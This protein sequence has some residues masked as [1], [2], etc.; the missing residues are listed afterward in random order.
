MSLPANMTTQ[1][2]TGSTTWAKCCKLKTNDGF[3]IGLTEH[4]RSLDVDLGDGDGPVTYTPADA[5]ELSDGRIA[6]DLSVD[7]VDVSGAVED[8]RVDQDDLHRGRYEGGTVTMFEVEFT[9]PAAGQKIHFKGIIGEGET[10]GDVFV[11]ELRSITSLFSRTISQTI[12]EQCRKSFGTT[13]DAAERV[14]NTACGVNLDPA[15]WVGTTAYTATEAGDRLVGDRV[16]PTAHTGF[17]F[18]CTTAGTSAASEPA[19]PTTVGDTVADG[20]VVWT[21]ERALKFPGTVSAATNLISF[22]ATGITVAA[23]YFARGRI[24][25][26]TGENADKGVQSPVAVDDGAGAI[27]LYKP[28]LEDIAIGDTF[29]IFRGCDKSQAACIGFSNWVNNNGFN[30]VP[31]RTVQ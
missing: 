16:S 3:L 11:L 5:V 27:R 24:E 4:D 10:I 21:A 30:Y 14:P 18:A 15:V 25:W 2:A 22:T 20:T 13:T 1:A 9:D 17:I 6:T 12:T 29:N 19:W 28:T 8:V 23:D 26:L 7:N 31:P